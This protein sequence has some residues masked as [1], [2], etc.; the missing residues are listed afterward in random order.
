MRRKKIMED[1]LTNAR[2]TANGAVHA[3]TC[4][5]NPAPPYVKLGT[6]AIV[7]TTLRGTLVL[8]HL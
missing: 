6:H 2:L 7:D 8:H 1:E 5:P 4:I 3:S